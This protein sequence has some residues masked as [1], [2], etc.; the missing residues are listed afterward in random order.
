MRKENLD[1]TCLDASELHRRLVLIEHSE[2]MEQKCVDAEE[3]ER[4]S[5][6]LF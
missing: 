1:N 2:Q 3:E 5:R 4:L 6:T